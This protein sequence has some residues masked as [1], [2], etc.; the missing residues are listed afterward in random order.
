[1]TD[2]EKALDTLFPS[3]EQ[4]E[5]L[6]G[7]IQAL[8]T[9]LKTVK[10]TLQ[11]NRDQLNNESWF[12]TAI[13]ALIANYWTHNVDRHTPEQMVAKA[14][15]LANLLWEAILKHRKQNDERNA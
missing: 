10:A 12:S 14:D 11:R 2:T 13:M 6:E 8:E 3:E 1:M 7:E 5:R 9:Q 15:H 4:K